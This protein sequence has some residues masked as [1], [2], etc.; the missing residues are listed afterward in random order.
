MCITTS[1]VP[2]E[3]LGI[4]CEPFFFPDAS[5]RRKHRCPHIASTRSALLTICVFHRIDTSAVIERII[6]LFQDQPFLIHNFNA[7]LPVGFHI[8]AGDQLITVIT[9]TGTTLVDMGM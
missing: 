5:T 6:T 4:N 7:F 8:E 2:C 1:W 9:P 3:T